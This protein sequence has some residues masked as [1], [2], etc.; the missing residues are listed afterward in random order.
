MKRV[1]KET[2]TRE[3]IY[4]NCLTASRNLAIKMYRVYHWLLDFILSQGYYTPSVRESIVLLTHVDIIYFIKTLHSMEIRP[5]GW[6]LW[7]L[8]TIAKISVWVFMYTFSWYSFPKCSPLTWVSV[9]S[10]TYISKK[11]DF[12]SHPDPKGCLC[13]FPCTYQC[14]A[15]THTH[16]TPI[17]TFWCAQVRTQLLFLCCWHMLGEDFIRDSWQNKLLSEGIKKGLKKEKGLLGQAEQKDRDGSGIRE[18]KRQWASVRIGKPLR[19]I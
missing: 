7:L 14:L 4:G 17:C 6:C 12:N 9:Y 10:S 1:S 11:N 2:Q 16:F 18:E 19:T 15:K 13:V 5:V 3:K 8:Q